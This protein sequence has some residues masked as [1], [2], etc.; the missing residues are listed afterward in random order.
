ML[1]PYFLQ[2]SSGEQSL[3]QSLINEQLKMYGV[4]IYYIPRRYITV[5]TVIKEVIQ[6]KFDNALPIEAYVDTYDG[7]EG[8]GT[9]L[10]KFG[11]QPL[12]DLTLI[13]SRERFETYITPLIQNIP[14]IELPTRP[15]EGDLVYFPLGD[16]L[17][18]I[19]FVEHEKPFYQLQK[20]YVYELRC[21]LFRYEDEELDTGVEYIDDNVEK[22]GYIETLTLTGSGS[23][24]TAIT[25]IVDGGIRFITIT[26]RGEKYTS[27]PRVAISSAPIG[28]LTAVGVAS[29]I[30][31]IVD[32]NGTTSLKVQ[33]VD[34]VNAGYG[35]TTPP[36][37]VFVG[38]G[39]VGAAATA[40]IGDGVVGIVTLTSGGSGYNTTPTVT[41]S[42]APA[43]GV[44]AT[45]VAY[46][47]NVGIV[48]QIG[49]TNA[50]LG[51]TI[52]P[53]I[54]I[55]SPYISGFGNYEFNEIVTGSISGTTA[56]VKSWNS[57]TNQLEVSILTGSFTN[58]ELI[59]GSE[60]GAEYQYRKTT[61]R[62]SEDAFAQNSVI[63]E[64]A[65]QI[66]DFSD[67]NPFG[68]P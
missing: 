61:I 4:E 22:S 45:G 36:S 64:E 15:K 13:I 19:K 25:G 56:K 2:G 59:V 17:F 32:C 42:S 46:L 35:Y 21:E 66:I 20:T 63:E 1:N 51:Y 30:S 14:D 68:M 55:S 10:S 6:S 16:R 23:T 41:F 3:V 65:D 7:Y 47:N 57:V 33:R 60:S 29:M 48:T 49:I 44:T 58:G 11:I 67:T 38:G 53:I 9:I 40:T 37:V 12:T 34:V 43:G 50:G 52:A 27:L 28:G 62:N 31:G 26:N 24:A 8:Q 54:T 5:N 39:G 18:E